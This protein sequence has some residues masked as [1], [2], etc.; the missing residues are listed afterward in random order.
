MGGL[1][2]SQFMAASKSSNQGLRV[3]SFDPGETTGWALLDKGELVECGQTLMDQFSF[4]QCDDLDTL[5]VDS[6]ADVVVYE[7]YRVYGWKADDHKWSEVHTAQVIGAIRQ[8]CVM[9]RIPYV[10]Q[11]AQHAKNFC[12]DDKLKLWKLWQ[13]GQRHARDAIRHASYF[14]IFGKYVPLKESPK[15]NR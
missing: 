12:T 14:Y 11:T 4:S 6:G 1:T 13:K 10:K 7:S 5:I 8:I 15:E 3:L 9:N 2:L